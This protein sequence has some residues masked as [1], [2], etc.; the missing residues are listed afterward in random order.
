VAKITFLGNF[1][2][3]FTSES[4]HSKTLESL[5]HE[6]IRLQ[7][8]EATAEMVLQNAMDSS[9]FIWVH[10]H[11]WNT[12]GRFTMED[13]LLKLKKHKIPSMTYHLDLWFGLRRQKD[14]RRKPVYQYIDHFFTV[15]RKMADWFNSNTS[16][17][18]HYLPA[19]VY[20]KECTY[21]PAIATEEVIF[22]G[23]KTYHQEWPYRPKLISFLSQT[24]GKRFN[25]YGREGVR[26]VRGQELNN[27][28]AATKVVVGD[29]LCPDFAYPDY[30]SDRIYETIGR[31]GFLIHPYI[32]GLEKEFEDKK[33]VVF[34]E[35]NNLDQ[36]KELVDYY[37][38][39]DEEREQIRRSGHE[40]VKNNYTYKNRWQTIL[41]EL[42]I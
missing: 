10:T 22:V 15:D 16:V 25:L 17:K 41:K 42:S 21:T 26:M 9:L 4:H 30:W 3:D 34:Y 14:L 37:L 20:D 33:H 2:V 40:L 32:K 38:E 13:V 27:L 28:Y 29:T 11:G 23:S 1:R 36:L 18:G 35:Y 6:V 12:I 39:H 19:G 7:E 8:S 31:G 24:Y 5:G